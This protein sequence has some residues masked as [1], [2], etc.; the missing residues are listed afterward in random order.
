MSD[1]LLFDTDVLIDAGRGVSEAIDTLAAAA[2]EDRIRISVITEM[3]LL[4]G[5]RDKE[6]QRTF[7]DFLDTYGAEIFQIHAAISADAAELMRRHQLSHN[8]RIP[9]ALIA[10]TARWRDCQLVTKNQKDFRPIDDLALPSYPP[11]I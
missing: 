11:P 7:Y 4:V 3:E 9:D 8:L 5:C 6:E 10:A 1:P 2:R